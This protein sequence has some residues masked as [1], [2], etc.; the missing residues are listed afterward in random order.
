MLLDWRDC[1]H[2]LARDFV[3]GWAEATP[4]DAPK[5]CDRCGLQTLCRIQ[6]SQFVVAGED[7]PGEEGNADE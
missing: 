7:E 4:R 3:A 2:Q 1:I 5:T 6:E